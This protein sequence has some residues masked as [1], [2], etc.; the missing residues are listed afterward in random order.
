V[1]IHRFLYALF[2]S[3]I[4]IAVASAQQNANSSRA[5]SIVIGPNGTVRVTRVVPVPTTV[6]R[7]AREELATATLGLDLHQ[8]LEQHRAAIQNWQR[9]WAKEHLNFTRSN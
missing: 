1:R 6:S 2:L 9:T 3:A 4:P 7:A 8:T 5:P